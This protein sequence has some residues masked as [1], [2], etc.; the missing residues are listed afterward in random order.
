M[1]RFSKIRPLLIKTTV[2]LVILSFSTPAVWGATDVYLIYSGKNKADKKLFKKAFPKDIKIKTYNADLLAVA[3]YSGIQ[4]AISKFDK[5]HVI[6]ILNDRPMEMLK[7]TRL[8][9]TLI[10]VQSLKKEVASENLRL[11]ILKEGTDLS[12]LGEG[13]R[14][15]DV[16]S[17]ND[18]ADEKE[19]RAADV[20]LIDEK[21]LEIQQA[22]SQL[23]KMKFGW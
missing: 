22:V 12:A 14:K 18:L 10:I 1:M 13:I 11:Y 9:K 6:V 17:I 7:G 19:I 3:D 5:A 2:F 15:K 21:T 16:A 20:L 8:K 4:K 23:I